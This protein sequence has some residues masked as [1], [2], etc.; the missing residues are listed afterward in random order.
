MMQGEPLRAAAYIRVSTEEQVEFS[1]ESQYR[2]ICRYAQR[3]GYVLP[4]A[5]IFRDVGISGRKAMNRPAFVEMIRMAGIRPRPFDVILVWK[6]SRFSRSRSDSIV[7]KS[8]L[9]K[10]GIRVLSVAEPLQEDPTSLLMEAM[11]EAMDEYYSVNLGQEVR[12]GMEEKFLRG[13][14]VSIPPFGY[15]VR[16]GAFMLEEREAF[17]VREMFRRALLGDSQRCIAR[18]L[19][20]MGAVTH[21][22]GAFHAREVG[23]I[24]R[25]PFYIGIQR[26]NGQE[27][28]GQQ[29]PLISEE[30]FLQVQ[31]HLPPIRRRKNKP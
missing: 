13:G 12:R 4:E 31:R 21:R 20:E 28:R 2:E 6:F 15:T 19:N 29:E 25:N 17:L 30:G 10:L 5:Y 8:K 14:V 16:D 26:R 23:Y 18:W 11:L 24:L 1:P 22:G 7:Y 27:V 3:E 9:K